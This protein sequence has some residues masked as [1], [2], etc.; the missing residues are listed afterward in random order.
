MYNIS[1]HNLISISLTNHH[2][3]YAMV[4]ER[5]GCQLLSL[6]VMNRPYLQQQWITLFKLAL[7]TL[8]VV[9]FETLTLPWLL[10]FVSS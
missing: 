10:R 4:R 8:P 3:R 6:L 5:L 9:C 2:K 7:S 1:N